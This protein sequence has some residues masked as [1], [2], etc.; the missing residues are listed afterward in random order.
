MIIQTPTS[1][2]SSQIK[3][4]IPKVVVV[5][6]SFAGLC[7]IR[8][9]KK[10]SN[11]LDIVLIDPKDYFEYTPGVLHL[12]SGSKSELIYPFSEIIS[13]KEDGN[14]RVIKG[15]FLN[16]NYNE[17]NKKKTVVVKLDKNKNDDASKN[18]SNGTGGSK[19]DRGKY[20][21]AGGE[22]ENEGEGDVCEVNYDAMIICSGQSYVTPIRTGMCITACSVFFLI[23]YN[24]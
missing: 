4:Y 19:D 24:M 5:G 22:R 8:H 2:P 11:K 14:T 23:I 12:L 3:P 20:N 21:N 15:R 7:T 18:G 13:E 9:L 17:K 10:Y 6:G 1:P 16:L